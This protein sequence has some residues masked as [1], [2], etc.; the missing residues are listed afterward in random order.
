MKLR[1]GQTLDGPD[2]GPNGAD[3]PSSRRRTPAE[4]AV[5]GLSRTAL[6]V[7]AVL[8]LASYFAPDLARQVLSRVLSAVRGP[9]KALPSASELRIVTREELALAGSHNAS[10]VHYLSIVGHVFDVSEGRSYYGPG[11]SYAF[12]SGTD[13]TRAFA[14]GEFNKEGLIETA[15]GLGPSGC[16]AI[17]NWLKFFLNHKRYRLLGYLEGSEYMDAATQTAAPALLRLRDC[18]SVGQQE[19]EAAKSKAFCNSEWD[20]RVGRKRVWCGEGA[21]GSGDMVPR[22][23]QYLAADGSLK[24]QCVCIPV[25]QITTRLD[26]L[27]YAGCGERALECE[28]SA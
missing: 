5:A 16:L 21:A 12:F 15:E 7:A 3:S 14:T 25:Q 17:D 13:G 27:P 22:K 1:T 4:A 18:A 28:F 6:V 11:G 24:D 26:V 10:G 23:A 9:G 8:G 20:L 19:S 2:G